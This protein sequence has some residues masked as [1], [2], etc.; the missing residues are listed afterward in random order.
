M[1][2]SRICLLSCVIVV[3]AD[4]GLGAQEESRVALQRVRDV[5]TRV[6]VLSEVISVRFDNLTV[7]AALRKIAASGQVRLLYGDAPVLT[8]RRVSLNLKDVTVEEALRAVLDG[9]GLDL[10]VS[11]SG[12]IVIAPA[13][14]DPPSP[15]PDEQ[16]AVVAGQVVDIHSRPLT[17]ARVSVVGTTTERLTDAAG[18]FRIDAAP[19]GDV[20][21]RVLMIG[22]QPLEQ[23]VRSGETNLRFVLTELAINLDE[24]VVTGTPG[25]VQKRSLGNAVTQIRAA[26]VVE[27]APIRDVGQ[28]LNG[29]APGVSVSFGS[30]TVGSGPQVSIR[31]IS[32]IVLNTHPLIYVDGVRVDNS[33]ATG[34]SAFAGAQ[35]ASRLNDVDPQDIE[36]IEIIKGP[37]AATLYGT[38]AANGVIQIITKRGRQGEGTTVSATVRQGANWF[39]N[40]EGRWRASF[41]RDPQ[42]GQVQELNVVQRERDRGTPIFSTGHLQGYGLNVSGGASSAQYYASADFARDEGVEPVNRAQRFSARANISTAPHPKVDLNANVGVTIGRTKLAREVGLSVMSAAI[43]ANAAT[44][45]GPTRGFLIAPPEAWWETNDLRQDVNRFIGGVQLNHR[46]ASWFQQRLTAGVDL[47]TEESSWL[48]PRMRPELAVFFTPTEMAGQKSTDLRNVVYTTVDYGATATATLGAK[49]SSSSSAGLQYY[50]KT[51]RIHGEDGRGFPAPGVTTVSGAAVR[52]GREDLIENTTIGAYFQQQLAWQDRLFL[53]GAVRADDNSAFGQNF[54]FVWYPKVSLAWVL[55]EEPFW[56]IG[57]VNSL[58]LRAAIG[59]SGQQP[60]AFAAIRT[61]EPVANAAGQPTVTPEFVG[62]PDLEPERGEALEAGFEAAL[63]KQR[64]GVDFTYYYQRTKNAIVLRDVAPSTGFPRQQFVNAGT[65]RNKGIEL[66]VRGRP[67]E[68]RRAAVDLTFTLATN[69]N[70]VLDLGLPGVPFI[71]VGFFQNRHQPGHPVNS[72]FLK[73]VVNADLAQNGTITNVLCDGGPGQAPLPCD[74]APRVFVGSWIPKVEGSLSSTVTLFDR[75]RLY[76]LLDF[77]SGHSRFSNNLDWGR[78]SILRFCEENVFPERFDPIRLAYVQLGGPGVIAAGFVSNA[79]F[80]K[81]REVSLDYTLPRSWTRG[82]GASQATITLSGRNLHTWTGYRGFDP[83]AV[84]LS[85]I[86]TPS[87]ASPVDQSITPQL[88]Q[89]VTT[90]RLI[91]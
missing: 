2:F 17:G 73:R 61:F 86:R 75:V 60:D 44:Q 6:V 81:L 54:D 51:T 52:F 23:T 29:R 90:V 68:A 55:N 78:C 28:L 39:M 63:F 57:F 12:Q 24:V 82:L 62:N 46:P 35:V 48:V 59:A 4:T 47:T 34:P 16:G 88:A 30:G 25:A 22:Y 42:T 5:G 13:A 15:L 33:V 10:Y 64:L 1:A 49:L 37:A 76:A 69:D 32:T 77:K 19:A 8:K 53:T 71:S 27:I 65:V 14:P 31:G 91:F 67:L 40:A 66:L 36:S 58:K 43:N 83:E 50:G 9:T 87:S 85:G 26:D 11:R 45:N 79:R 70:E 80:A 72:Y 18:R 21:L 38:E 56:N 7:A 3:L 41:F 89:F 84:A 74:Q 20:R